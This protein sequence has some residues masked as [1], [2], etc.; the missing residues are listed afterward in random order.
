MDPPPLHI[1]ITSKGLSGFTLLNSNAWCKASISVLGAVSPCTVAGIRVTWLIGALLL[2]VV[3]TS[4]NAAVDSEVITPI[5][6]GWAGKDSFAACENNPSASNFFF[7][8]SNC[9]IKLPEPAGC[10][11]LTI[12]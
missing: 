12:S 1:K 2:I 8:S 7:N 11:E 10:I 3:N 9:C 5:C 4:C 6:L